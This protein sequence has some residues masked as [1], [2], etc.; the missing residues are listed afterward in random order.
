MAIN[1]Y[2]TLNPGVCTGGV[3]KTF[4]FFNFVLYTTHGDVYSAPHL[5]SVA[6]RLKAPVLKTGDP[7]G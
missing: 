6:E 1:R 4:K 5:G 2:R 7:K 3:W